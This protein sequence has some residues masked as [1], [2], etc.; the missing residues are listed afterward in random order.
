MGVFIKKNNGR[1][2]IPYFFNTFWGIGKK[3]NIMQGKVIA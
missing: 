2:M 3:I 1:N